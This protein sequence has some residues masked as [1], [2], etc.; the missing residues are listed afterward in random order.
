MTK[1]EY[2]C[3]KYTYIQQTQPNLPRMYPYIKCPT[4]GC[5][6]G[7]LYRLFQAMRT[8]KNE[9]DEEDKNLMDIF[10]ILKVKN[11]CCRTRMMTARQFNDFLHE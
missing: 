11:Y 1:I 6:I 10:D 8:I 5:F 9:S 2:L 4:C 3:Y 7:H